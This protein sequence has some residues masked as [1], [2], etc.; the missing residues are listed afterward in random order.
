GA[1]ALRRHAPP[2]RRRPLLPGPHPGRLRRRFRLGDLWPDDAHEHVQDL[3]LML[4][5]TYVHLRGVGYSTERRL[6]RAGA[7]CWDDFLARTPDVRMGPARL[8]ELAERV[9]VSRERLA[10][11]DYRFFG[12]Q[13][14]RRDQW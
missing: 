3:H 4:T 1:G 12:E 11:R 5:S 2:H 14:A 7:R 8:A 13:L 6:W 10:A 9:A